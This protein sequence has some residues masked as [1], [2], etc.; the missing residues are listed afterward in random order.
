MANT[1]PSTTGCLVVGEYV[2]EAEIA[3]DEPLGRSEA[4]RTDVVA[5]FVD[6]WTSDDG[7]REFTVLMNDGR[8]AVVRGH[9]LK[10]DPHPLA[11][12]DVFRV[13]VRTETGESNVAVFKG[14]EVTGIF[15]GDLRVDSMTA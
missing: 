15:H 4:A 6:N 3:T 1:I 11:G 5:S 13:V 7:L 14:S 8:I 9:Q 12:Q 2:D 10:H